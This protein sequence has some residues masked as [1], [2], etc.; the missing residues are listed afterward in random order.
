MKLTLLSNV[1]PWIRNDIVLGLET[2]LG[3]KSC[4]ESCSSDVIRKANY[5]FET[6]LYKHIP[7]PKPGK[8]TQIVQWDHNSAAVLVMPDIIKETDLPS[9]T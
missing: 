6:V 1:F 5:F 4:M 3:T 9:S 8:S 7:K 2:K